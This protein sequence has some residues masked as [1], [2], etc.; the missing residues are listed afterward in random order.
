M[1]NMG[2]R[3]AKVEEQSSN[4]ASTVRGTQHALICTSQASAVSARMRRA[5]LTLIKAPDNLQRRM[6]IR[7]VI[8]STERKVF[9][10]KSNRLIEWT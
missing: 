10:L 1:L 3:H 8:I 2:T 5:E 4:D 6:Y 7:L 9:L